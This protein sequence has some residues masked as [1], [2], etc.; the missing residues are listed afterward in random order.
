MKKQEL[1]AV[2]N[3]EQDRPA[4]QAQSIESKRGAICRFNSR[5]Q[6]ELSTKQHTT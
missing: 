6:P 1:E 5:R 4:V 2:T 3:D